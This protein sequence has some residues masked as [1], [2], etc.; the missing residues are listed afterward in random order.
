MMKYFKTI[1][2]FC[3]NAFIRDKSIPGFVIGGIFFELIEIF[4]TIIFFNVIFDNTK[5]L[6]GWNF[7][8]TLF[9]YSFVKVIF[10]LNNAFFKGG[11]KSLAREM[12]RQGT[13]DFHLTKPMNSLVL[14]IISKP[15]I[16]PLINCLFAIA[17]AG[18]AVIAGNIPISFVQL[19][20]LI[21][22]SF[23]SLILYICLQ[24]ILVIPVF[25]LTKVWSLQSII[26]RLSQFMRYPARMFPPVLKTILLIIFPI[27]T[28]SYVPVATFLE[29]P[30]FKLIFFIIFAT[31]VFSLLTQ[32]FWNF[33]LKKY[34]SAS[35]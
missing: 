23:F 8:Q 5:S 19:I 11:I 1:Y 13:L 25:W 28:V 30:R 3:K 6:G 18:Y 27:L 2:V 34:T 12:I 26:G 9:L 24:L 31:L 33:G 20:W 7:Y 15:R 35:S 16:Y 4:T 29:P 10:G 14:M 17:L 22:L 32:A 21:F